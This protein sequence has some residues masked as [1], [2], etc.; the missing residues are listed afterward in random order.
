MRLALWYLD[1]IVR[2]IGDTVDRYLIWAVEAGSPMLRELLG[3]RERSHLSL[4]RQPK[5]EE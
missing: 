1:P 4:R 5:P 2:A 3:I